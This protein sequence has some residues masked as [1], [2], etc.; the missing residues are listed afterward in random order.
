MVSAKSGRWHVE[1]TTTQRYFSSARHWRS[2]QVPVVD[3]G[4]SKLFA[5]A[6]DAV[7]DIKSGSVILSSGFGL[8]GVAGQLTRAGDLPDRYETG[9]TS[10]C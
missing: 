1:H 4:D 2:A 8:C 9:R 7:A 5:S 10:N 3:R 6:D